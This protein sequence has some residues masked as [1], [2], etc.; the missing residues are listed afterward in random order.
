MIASTRRTLPCPRR[1]AEKY[2]IYVYSKPLFIY[3]QG[4]VPDR[5]ATTYRVALCKSASGVNRDN[6]LP[7]A[8][9]PPTLINLQDVATGVF[10]GSSLGTLK[11]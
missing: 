5:D 3:S 2:F 10:K 11:R 9:D 4:R 7:S 8:F 6:S 1:G